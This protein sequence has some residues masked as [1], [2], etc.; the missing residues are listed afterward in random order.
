MKLRP[1][2]LPCI[3]HQ[4]LQVARAA[5]E[6]EWSQRKVL[7]KVLGALPDADWENTPADL[8]EDALEATRDTLKVSDPYSDHRQKVQTR[9]ATL[10]ATFADG[11]ADAEDRVA[12]AILGAAAANMVDELVFLRF[13][14]ADLAA[15]F[16]EALAAGLAVGSLDQLREAI[17][18]ASSVLYIL[19]NAG[20]V[21]FDAILIGELR[22]LGKQVRVAVRGG[23]L[24]HD[25]TL[26]DALA[27]GLGPDGPVTI[28][29]VEPPETA[30][31]AAEPAPAA[32]PPEE[33]GESTPPDVVELKTGRLAVARSRELTL[34]IEASDLVIAKGSASYETLRVPE[35]DVYHLL[36][37]KCRPV[38]QSLGVAPGALV[39]HRVPGTPPTDA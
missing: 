23:G 6:D 1:D 35:R 36:R 4:A 19:D 2:C 21:H 17:D 27:A 12:R 16:D 37:A 15:V 9:L 7:A 20:E 28:E 30:E 32:P 5:S 34:A 31:E 18:A 3:L 10:A 24:L 26:E 13:S 22:S 39:L 29:E 8:L 11:Q 33:D 25:A 14:K 38:A